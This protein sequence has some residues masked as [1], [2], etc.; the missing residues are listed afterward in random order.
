MELPTPCANHLPKETR[1]FK[2]KQ[3][4]LFP[5]AYRT[6]NSLLE[7][8][9]VFSSGTAPNTCAEDPRDR[10][11]NEAS[12][13]NI[14]KLR[15]QEGVMLQPAQVGVVILDRSNVAFID[16]TALQ[17]LADARKYLVLFA[18]ENLL[19]GFVGMNDAV[20]VKFETSG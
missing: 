11:W 19:F 10:L 12:S 1:I 9:Q 2:F 3:S 17:A 8:V 14:P 5:N 16:T 15:E 20:R 18:G 7:S 13:D 6:K 4:I